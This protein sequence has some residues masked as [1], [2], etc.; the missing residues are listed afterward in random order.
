ALAIDR[1]LDLFIEW[2][3]GA[4]QLSRGN[5]VQRDQEHV[6]AV[7]RKR[8]HDR[9]AATRTGGG[10]LDLVPLRRQTGNLVRRRRL[11]RPRIADREA[12]DGTRRVEVRVQQG[13]RRELH[14]GD[15]VEVG[16]L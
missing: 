16:A 12:T 13:R 2:G 10:A 11:P 14:I 4:I 7:G 1:D 9:D 15:V 3:G 6:L 5:R 8:V